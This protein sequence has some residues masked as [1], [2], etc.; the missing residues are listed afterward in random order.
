MRKTTKMIMPTIWTR[1]SLLD[2]SKRLLDE[3]F[4]IE[5]YT[6]SF[7]PVSKDPERMFSLCRYSRNYLQCRMTVENVV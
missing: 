4:Y 1:M 2:F 3:N 7:R 6:K 5:N